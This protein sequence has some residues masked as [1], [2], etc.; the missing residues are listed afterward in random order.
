MQW[1]SHS[2]AVRLAAG[3]V[4]IILF[5]YALA[6]LALYKSKQQHELQ[7]IITTENLARSLAINVSG[8]LDKVDVGLFAVTSEVERQMAVGGINGALLNGYLAQQQAQIRDCEGLWVADEKGDVPWGTLMTA[9]KVTNITDREY[10]QRLH[11]NSHLGMVVSRPVI[12]RSTKTWSVLLSRRINYAD[13]SFAGVALGSL[14]MMEYFSD[15]FSTIDVGKQGVIAIRDDEMALIVRYPK[16]ANESGQVGARLVSA[17]ATE[18]TRSSPNAGNYTA[19]APVDGIERLYSYRKIAN[20]PLYIFVAKSTDDILAPWRKEVVITLL[21]VAIFTLVILVYT[22]TSYRR[23]TE[24]RKTKKMELFRTVFRTSPDSQ[25]ITRLEDGRLLEVN[26]GFTPVFGWTRE[27]TIGKTVFDIDIWRYPEERHKSVCLLQQNGYF[28]DREAEFV[29]KD[30][31]TWPGLVSAH[32]M[33]LDDTLCIQAIV[34][35]ISDRKAAEQQIQRLSFADQLT[36]LPNRRLFMDRLE[37]ALI[38]SARHQWMG[39]LMFVDLDDFKSINETLGHGQGDLILNEV[40]QRLRRCVREGDTVA[41]LGGD[42]FALILESQSTNP[43]EAASHA[44]N[45]GEKTLR[46]I[47]QPY[48]VCTSILHRTCSIGITLFGEQHEDA[49]E[50]LKRAELA[51]YQAKACG[52]NVLRFFDPQMQAIVSARI[53]LEDGLRKAI[54]Q[55]HILLHYQPQVTDE[56]RITGVEAL[57]RWKDLRGGMIFP[58]EFIPL[59]EASGLILPLGQ[60]ALEIACQQLAAWAD[61]SEFSHLSIAVN[62]STRQ[63]NQDDFVEQI[64]SVLKRYGANPHR[65]KLEITESML[66]SNVEDVI[67]KMNALKSIG[68]VFSLDDFGTGYSSLSYLKRLPLDQLKIDQGFVRD[69]LVDLND[70]A[71]AKTVVALANSMNLSVIAEG[72]E[73]EA[74]RDMLAALGCRNYQGY[75]FGPPMD[76]DALEDFIEGGIGL[77]LLDRSGYR[78]K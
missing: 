21:L 2:L 55:H 12:G 29:S 42:K 31:R 45:I 8:I 18:T 49:S 38:S 78:S 75:L 19:V 26:D 41:R 30:G 52:R 36:G 34:R 68:V 54:K 72:V 16:A 44:E 59:A 3:I 47:E 23:E 13:G 64:R 22:H 37:Q 46:E 32:M 4:S 60:Q 17:K 77:V 73:T 28:I 71:I 69:I 50:P 56:G 33:T 20:Y 70:A 57:V 48:D 35:E 1:R 15:M 58:A 24:S 11:E 66:V 39:A 76:I 6:G 14:R 7:A 67:A 25:V 61:R 63:F 43:Q 51:M 10:F 27:D 40:A 65:L 62:V 74:Q 53:A 5:V 9:G